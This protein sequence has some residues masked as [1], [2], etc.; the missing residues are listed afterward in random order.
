MKMYRF[1]FYM[2]TA[3]VPF[4]TILGS[5]TKTGYEH[6]SRTRSE[7]SHSEKDPL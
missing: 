3:S 5:K 6:E 2:L 7:A 4:V 1:G